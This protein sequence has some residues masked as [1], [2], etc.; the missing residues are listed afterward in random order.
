MHSRRT[1]ADGTGRQRR[2]SSPPRVPVTTSTELDDAR[3]RHRGDRVDSGAAAGGPVS[4]G[5]PELRRGR[6]RRRDV[7]RSSSRT[8][9]T[10]SRSSS[11]TP[12]TTTWPTSPATST[13]SPSTSAASSTSST[14]RRTAP[15]PSR[16]RPATA[17]ATPTRRKPLLDEKGITLLDPS[18]A[19]DTNA[20]FVTQEYSE[21]NGVTKLSD[22]EGKS[23][24]ARR[25]TRLRGPDRLRGRPH[26]RLRHR[27]H[28][29]AARSATPAT[30]TYQSVLNDESQLGET[31]TTDGTLESQGLVLLEDDKQH[32]AGP[33][34]R[35]GHLHR[36]PRRPP[37]RRGRPQRADGRAR[38]PRTSPSSTAGSRS[39][40]RSRRTSPAFL[41]EGAALDGPRSEAAPSSPRWPG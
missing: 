32:P 41:T 9:A 19:T 16:S 20:F 22:L 25:R 3:R 14:R 6:P 36:V 34:P 38:P 31:S 7:R 37:G 4:P 11:S 30:Q 35:A 39:T 40:A 28:R 23:R 10:T 5:G 17:G 12:A 8:P 24:R 33:E 15:T 1:L 26:R 27:R 29:G 2:S 21:A 18:E 13:S